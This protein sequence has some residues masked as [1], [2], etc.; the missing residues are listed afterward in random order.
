MKILNKD[1]IGIDSSRKFFPE[2]LRKSFSVTETVYQSLLLGCLVGIT[3]RDSA[4]CHL[5]GQVNIFIVVHS[6]QNSY[7]S[8]D[9][10]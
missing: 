8:M 6:G 4:F 3:G 1:K 9:F 5:G 10:L 7:E 2:V